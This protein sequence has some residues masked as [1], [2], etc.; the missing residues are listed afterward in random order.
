[1]LKKPT[2]S[3][4]FKNS[5][6]NLK[7]FKI[8][9]MLN[10]VIPLFLLFI[11]TLG[12]S[13]V[14]T[15]NVMNEGSK[16]YIDAL[17]ESYN[18][19]IQLEVESIVRF[20]NY[21]YS[22]V[23]TGTLSKAE[24]VT[25]VESF[26][27]TVNSSDSNDSGFWIFDTSGNIIVKPLDEITQKETINNSEY[28]KFLKKI[29][30]VSQSEKGYTYADFDYKA[31]DSKTSYSKTTYFYYFKPYDWV[32]S[33]AYKNNELKES[34]NEYI[35]T[36]NKKLSS[37]NMTCFIV[38]YILFLASSV[39]S[40]YVGIN[41]TTWV[42]ELFNLT[43]SMK[44]GI[45]TNRLEYDYK[46]ELRD[47]SIAINEVQD[48]FV[49]LISKIDNIA[50]SLKSSISTFTEN[51][52]KMNSSIDS[53]S[54]SVYD[55]TENINHQALATSNMSANINDISE[56]IKNTSMEIETLTETSEAMQNYSTKSMDSLNK[57]L[58]INDRSKK[59]I[60]EM[61]NQTKYTNDSVEKISKAAELINQIAS[62][63]N[64][65]SLNASI[66]AARAGENGKG[67]A[68]V[69][70][71]IGNLAT[72][73]STT[74][75]EINTLLDELTSN[76]SKSIEIVKEMTNASGVQNATILE[77]NETFNNLMEKLDICINSIKTIYSH[78]Q[79]VNQKRN[80]IEKNLEQLNDISANNAASTEET[81]AMSEE[82]TDMVTKSSNEISSLAKEFDTLTDSINNFTFK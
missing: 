50:S 22:K 61:Y 33:T 15:Y 58:S 14:M 49:E 55:I 26:L 45:L 40:G 73:S 56:S 82:L 71:E 48:N 27:K 68:V 51:H 30:E 76:S 64:L 60:E 63:T 69:A 1:M 74:V 29:Q 6:N 25:N 59:D 44:K 66:E 62:Q 31:N 39:A 75:K 10:N 46:H 67:F 37:A 23:N 70:S 78:I 8:R 9:M 80:I 2:L 4:Y 42:R 18:K 13:N 32:I 52:I 77:T 36:T 20:L 3:F 35:S 38:G 79:I 11:I 17:T 53:V 12:V 54:H 34:I 81:A 19:E 57:L 47:T 21:D 5:F 43:N 41:I 72:Q 24:A 65:L 16:R 7:G 28:D